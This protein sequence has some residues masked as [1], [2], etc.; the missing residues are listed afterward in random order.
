MTIGQST[1]IRRDAFSGGAKVAGRPDAGK[2]HRGRMRLPQA[3]GKI[4]CTAQHTIVER[5]LCHCPY[6]PTSPSNQNLQTVFGLPAV[7]VGTSLWS[8]CR[9]AYDQRRRW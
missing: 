1:P 4:Q 9:P 5:C 2:V 8:G 7:I 6:P 3:F